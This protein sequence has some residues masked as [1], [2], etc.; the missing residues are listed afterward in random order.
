MINGLY[1]GAAAMNML[2]K[3]QEV[4]SSNLMHVNSSG[5][6][7]T[8]VGVKQRFDL[9]NVDVNIDLGPQVHKLQRSFEAGRR[10]NT[11]RPL[12]VAITGDGFFVFDVDGTEHY[13]RNGRLFRDPDSNLI[14][15]E[16]G[17]PIQG[18]NGPITIQPIVSDRDIAIATDGTIS[19]QGV[20]IGK[21]KMVAFSDN[22]SLKPVGIAS[23]VRTD[24]S[25]ESE[26][27]PSVTQ[28][29]HEL[30]NVQ[31]VSELVSMIV[32]NRQYEAVQRATRALAD[33]LRE[34]IRE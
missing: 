34:Y 20:E 3:Q 25:I 33:S 30:S 12:D 18:E 21:L 8:Q 26:N 14:I 9:E 5:H 13:S 6:R 4:I 31:P 23:F 7:R 32:N 15:N 29:H 10:L 28:F 1:S 11:D 17:Y 19:A 22:Q 27:K 2:A 24:D 16:E